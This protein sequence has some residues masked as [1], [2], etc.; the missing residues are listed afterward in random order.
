ML[1]SNKT[2]SITFI[3]G[4]SKFTSVV[5]RRC[6]IVSVKMI[7]IQSTVTGKECYMNK[8][9]RGSDGKAHQR[10]ILLL[11]GLAVSQHNKK[12]RY[13]GDKIHARHISK[14]GTD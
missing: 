5:W 6:G 4:T 10:T 13:E 8:G 12:K 1:V 2:C 14:T 9:Q 11:C 7:E 3:K